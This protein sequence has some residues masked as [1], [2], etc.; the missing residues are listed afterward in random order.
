MR[1]ILILIALLL[2]LTGC[3]G[4]KSENKKNPEKLNTVEV[5]E[6]GVIENKEYYGIRIEDIDF[7]FDG[8]YT[9]MSFNLINSRSE[10]VTLGRYDVIVSDSKGE[11]IGRLESYSNEEIPQGGSLEFSLSLDKDFSKAS[12]VEFDFIDLIAAQ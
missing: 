12:S 9:T 3:F 8:K 2:V 6:K 11:E 10:A 5:K 1:K 7:I 4:K